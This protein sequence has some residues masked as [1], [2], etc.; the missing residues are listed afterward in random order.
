MSTCNPKQTWDKN[1]IPLSTISWEPLAAGLAHL[2][3][4]WHMTVGLHSYHHIFQIAWA[5][6]DAC[7]EHLLHLSPTPFIPDTLTATPK[8]MSCVLNPLRMLSSAKLWETLFLPLL[9]SSKFSVL[10]WLVFPFH[11]KTNKKI[12]TILCHRIIH[13]SPALPKSDSVQGSCFPHCP[14]IEGCSFSQPSPERWGAES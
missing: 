10:S 12:N 4:L 7:L 2:C 14:P 13:L 1:H 9:I 11:C 8:Q 3:C 6:T 5:S